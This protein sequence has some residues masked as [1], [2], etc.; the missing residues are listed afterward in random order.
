M[1]DWRLVGRQGRLVFAMLAY[2]HWRTVHRDELV[3]QLWPDEPPPSWDRA[4]NAIVS[5]V[6][7][8]IDSVDAPG[9]SLVGAYGG[10]HLRLPACAWIDVEAAAAGIDAAEG[11]MRAGTP[12]D[13]WGHAQV[14]CHIARRPFLPEEDGTWAARVRADLRDV[15]VRSHECLSEIYIG[16]GETTTAVRHAMRAIEAEPFR[17]SAYRLLMTAH[18][19]AGNRAEAL[20]AFEQLRCLLSDELGVSPSPETQALVDS[21]LGAGNR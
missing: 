4:L 6:R 9:L 15:L 3:E 19:A 5:K 1:G 11:K 2:E 8:L 13:A 10:Y 20:R 21:I 17:E 18:A 7:S 16:S 14:A 12:R